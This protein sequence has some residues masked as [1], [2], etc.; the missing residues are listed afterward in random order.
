MQYCI[1]FV[2]LLRLSV[3]LGFGPFYSIEL[4]IIIIINYLIGGR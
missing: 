3:L 1:S 4:T 2:I